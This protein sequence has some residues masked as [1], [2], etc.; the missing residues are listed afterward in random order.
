[1]S[2]RN[3]TTVTVEGPSA[4]MTRFGE[5]GIRIVGRLSEERGRDLTAEYTEALFASRGTLEW[6]QSQRDEM[7]SGTRTVTSEDG[8]ERQVAMLPAM[9]ASRTDEMRDAGCTE[10]MRLLYNNDKAELERELQ[11]AGFSQTGSPRYVLLDTGEHTTNG[12]RSIHEGVMLVD[13]DVSPPR[14]TVIYR[15]T[16]DG[17]DFQS[18]VNGALDFTFGQRIGT[19]VDNYAR[20]SEGS[21][22]THAIINAEIERLR[23]AHPEQASGIGLTFFGHSLG[24]DPAAR[25]AAHFNRQYPD[26][27]VDYVGIGAA[28]SLSRGERREMSTAIRGREM[29]IYNED[30][31]LA[32]VSSLL[33][34]FNGMDSL[35]GSGSNR[36]E[37]QEDRIGVRAGHTYYDS[38][39]MRGF[40]ANIRQYINVGAD[41][42]QTRLA[43]VIQRTE[44]GQALED[45]VD[46]MG[47]LAHNQ[48]TEI[49]LEYDLAC[50]ERAAAA[51]ASQTEHVSEANMLAD[52]TTATADAVAGIFNVAQALPANFLT[53]ID[54]YNNPNWQPTAPANDD[55]EPTAP[56]IV[57]AMANDLTAG[58]GSR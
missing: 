39:L 51:L 30:D 24:A 11:S 7:L 42:W 21:D 38:M 13:E 6:V 22:G 25:E 57:V 17:E 23:E 58:V 43:D 52:A 27:E 12:G 33:R 8:T 45:R 5:D 16:K 3:N 32:N 34:P 20:M 54:Q 53:A 14:I 18:H 31:P 15:G 46:Y 40:E 50:A 36:G 26:M 47:Q 9:L 49:C 48:L 37:G 35:G 19:Y 56:A 2:R 41:G 28:S 29:E 55:Q 1:M 4:D 44:P 10:V